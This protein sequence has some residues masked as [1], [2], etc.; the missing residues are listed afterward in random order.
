[1]RGGVYGDGKPT[2]PFT[3]SELFLLGA[4]TTTMAPGGY[5]TVFRFC[6][7]RRVEQKR[8]T[9]SEWVRYNLISYRITR[10]KGLK[11]PVRPTKNAKTSV[12]S[13]GGWT[14]I[15]GSLRPPTITLILYIL[16]AACSYDFLFS[17]QKQHFV[18][19]CCSTVPLNRNNSRR[20]TIHVILCL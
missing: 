11:I 1:M 7:Q 19:C 14:W 3:P 5:S 6:K 9:E 20:S 4:L 13:A 17:L 12:T 16:Y 8:Q 2:R 15:R 18:Y 10:V